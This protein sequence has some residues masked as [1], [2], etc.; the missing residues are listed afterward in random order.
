MKQTIVF[1]FK[2]LNEPVTLK[3]CQI[4]FSEDFNA[5]TTNPLIES[6]QELHGVILISPNDETFDLYNYLSK[7][8]DL[9]FR[10]IDNIESINNEMIET[11]ILQQLDHES[12]VGVTVI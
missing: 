3:S 10:Q 2:Q 8:G 7:L 6:L 11:I 1:G 5:E 9:N 4:E 12:V